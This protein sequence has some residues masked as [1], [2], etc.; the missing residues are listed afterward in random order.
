MPKRLN[1]ANRNFTLKVSVN[2]RVVDYLHTHK[3]SRFSQHLQAIEFSQPGTKAYIKVYYGRF[4]DVHGKMTAFH[5][6]GEYN[7]RKDLIKAYLAF[8]E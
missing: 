1:L 8:K 6:I 4:K 2:G 7:N 3:L 5:N